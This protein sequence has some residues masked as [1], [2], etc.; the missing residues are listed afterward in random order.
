[1]R[2]DSKLKGRRPSI[3]NHEPA[4][5][6]VLGAADMGDGN[7]NYSAIQVQ[8]DDGGD[9]MRGCDEVTG[10]TGTADPTQLTHEQRL[11]LK[12]LERF[13]I[14]VAKKDGTNTKRKSR[15]TAKTAGQRDSVEFDNLFSDTQTA[16][17]EIRFVMYPWPMWVFGVLIIIATSIY[18]DQ[19]HRRALAAELENIDGGHQWWK[20]LVGFAVYLLAVALIANG[21]VE[22][23][24]MNRDTGRVVIRS[25]KPFC[26]IAKLRRERNVDR[27][28]RHI[29]DVRV[30]ASG[31]FSGDSDTRSYKLH[32][33]FHDAT[34]AYALEA[35]SK[36]KAQ[37][38]CRMIKHFLAASAGSGAALNSSSASIGPEESTVELNVDRT[39]PQ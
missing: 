1:M 34:H 11:G 36:R 35:R 13:K 27:D 32:F 15:W 2:G 21:R 18:M 37:Y 19:V 14:A 25:T 6:P 38:R 5:T 4:L 23:V 22:T 33:D 9:E 30:E 24:C 20:Y 29:R 3:E 8:D 31:E 7:T 16:A 28:L 17:R 12:Q 39:E 26:L 10:V